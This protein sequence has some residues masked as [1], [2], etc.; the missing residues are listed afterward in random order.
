MEKK[1]NNNLLIIGGIILVIVVLVI[2]LFMTMG[3][4]KEEVPN[5][6]NQNNNSENNNQN[7]N[8]NNNNENNNET[9]NNENNNNSNNTPSNMR[10]VTIG[11]L[12]FSI[13]KEFKNS[14]KNSDVY[15][16]YN[17]MTDTDFCMITVNKKSINGNIAPKNYFKSYMSVSDDNLNDIKTEKINNIT[18]NKVIINGYAEN[19]DYY[20]VYMDKN[21]AYDIHFMIYSGKDKCDKFFND[22]KSTLKLK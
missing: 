2:I 5:N 13:T 16:M 10:N 6:N 20:Y 14:G 9:G 3:N 7:D 1:K 17:Y 15:Q 21:T 4:N 8:E 19:A 18:W 12:S 22:I 11:D